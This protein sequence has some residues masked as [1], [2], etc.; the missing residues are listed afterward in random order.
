MLRNC[1][2]REVSRFFGSDSPMTCVADALRYDRGVIDQLQ[3]T[4][5]RKV[6]RALHAASAALLVA[7][8]PTLR[9][10]K[11]M[12]EANLNEAT[13]NCVR[14]SGIDLSGADLNNAS[15]ND[16]DLSN[17]RF[18]GA[19]FHSA[20]LRRVD[21]RGSQSARCFSW[22]GRFLSCRSPECQNGTRAGGVCQHLRRGSERTYAG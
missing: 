18:A 3:K 21:L 7:I 17:A 13:L 1:G 10:R 8:D 15:L 5:T 2:R 22:C 16:A 19:T 11:V 4:L 12:R 6:D 14:W 20:S 9:P